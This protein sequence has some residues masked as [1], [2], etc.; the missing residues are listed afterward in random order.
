MN[1][2]GNWNSFQW[3]WNLIYSLVL[4]AFSQ[5]SIPSVHAQVP[6]DAVRVE[7]TIFYAIENLDAGSVDRR[8]LAGSGGVLFDELILAP[9]TRYRVWLL[10]KATL[11]TADKKILTPNA[12]LRAKMPDFFFGDASSPDSDGDGLHDL[13]EFIIGTIGLD[14]DSDDDGILDGAEIA[15]G[16]DP[17]GGLIARTGIIGSADTPGEAQDVAAFNDVVVIADSQT[18]IS[19]FNIFNAMDPFIIAQVNTPGDARA[20][21]L[22]GSLIAVADGDEGLVIIDVTDP[23]AASI[24]HQIP[25]GKTTI[26]VATDGQFAF[27]G[28]ADGNVVALEMGTGLEVNRL[29]PTVVSP[30]DDLR[31]YGGR[32]YALSQHTLHVLEFVDGQLS[33]LSSETFDGDRNQN[34]PQRLRLF[35]GG[36]IA[37]AVHT[38]GYA[39]MD[40]SNPANPSLIGNAITGQFGW[41]HLVGNG[42][43]L[44]LVASAPNSTFDGPHDVSIYDISDPAVTDNFLTSF[45][46][47]GVARAVALYNGIGYVADHTSGLHVVNYLAFDAQGVP[48]TVTVVEPVDGSTVEESSLFRVQ[49]DVEDDVQVRNVEFYVDDLLLK[50]DGNFPFE[51]TLPAGGLNVRNSITVVARAS[52]TGGNASFSDPITLNLIPDATPPRINIVR[53]ANNALVGETNGFTIFFSEAVDSDTVGELSVT[54][55]WEGADGLLGTGDD[56]LV[57][58][59]AFTQSEDGSVVSYAMNEP[60]EAGYYQ[61]SVGKTVADNT[62]N[63]IE[64]RFTSVFLALGGADSD[65]DGLQDVVEL[66]YGF[67][68]LDP[69]SD[70]NGIFDGLE[71]T[72]GDGI[73]NGVEAVLGFALDQKDTDLDGIDDDKEDRD[74]DGLV[75][76]REIELGADVDAIDS[77]GDGFADGAEF[78]GDSNPVD[79]LDRPFMLLVTRPGIYMTNLS[80]KNGTFSPSLLVGKPPLSIDTQ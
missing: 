30:I 60:L 43:G 52:D 1:R 55:T 80:A 74:A 21:A 3:D 17:L 72:D 63:Q 5:V 34:A 56:V 36:D 13:A 51:V 22:A 29:R 2:P 48:P 25:L 50:T 18:G 57:S 77:D 6:L 69:D 10:D 62:G 54:L 26:S 40:V 16:L 32:I 7:G 79:P 27:V 49:V 19:V 73:T 61:I 24:R 68:P 8:G 9:N 76:F 14:P 71:D 47:P 23:P 44:G 31:L 41:K 28:L 53:P 33:E 46:T 38:R 12:G 78:E 37:Y 4:C 20:V 64:K 66:T 65:R 11:K 45:E 70:D 42:N 67:D 59:G 58:G 39:T 35:V 75:D 15:Q